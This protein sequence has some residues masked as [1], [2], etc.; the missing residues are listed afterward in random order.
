MRAPEP[1]D[2]NVPPTSSAAVAVL[3]NEDVGALSID[4]LAG[5]WRIV[6]RRRGHRFSTDDLMTAW[7]AAHARPEASRLCDLGAGIG[8]V[9]LLTLWRLRQTLRFG[10]QGASPH[11]TMVEVQAVSHAL[12]RRTV[13][14][15]GLDADVSAIASDLRTAEVLNG[16]RRFELVTGS[17]PYLPPGSAVISMDSQK[18]GARFELRGDVFD[19]CHAAARILDDDGVFV[20]CHAAK[21]P[22]PEAAITAAGLECVD[23]LDVIF[24]SDQPPL[25]AI[26]TARRRADYVAQRR[27][28]VVRDPSGR[29][30]D[31]YLA[32]RADM[33]T[34]VWNPTT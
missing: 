12:A 3:E 34:V 24:R 21:D 1:N 22:R 20:F 30:T 15:N 29:W 8:S 2:L 28:F 16:D 31:D 5:D 25:I 17:P 18:A 7:V 13:S 9:G 26:W 23:R 11:L 4:R 10:A 33:G 6:Q 27:S 14:L 32:M 19:Y